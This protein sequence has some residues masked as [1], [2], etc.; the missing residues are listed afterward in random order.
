MTRFD[1][2]ELNVRR[3]V[4]S[5]FDPE[6]TRIL[7]YF[8]E[9]SFRKGRTAA[10][11]RT[12]RDLGEASGTAS[13]AHEA[14]KRLVSK[15]VLVR[16]PLA[17]LPIAVQAFHWYGFNLNFL[18]WPPEWKRPASF[19]EE[20]ELPFEPGFEELLRQS[21]IN[22]S[23]AG[24]PSAVSEPT[25][26][27]DAGPAA[28]HDADKDAPGCDASERSTSAGET[29]AQNTGCEVQNG[30]TAE[31]A[32]GAPDWAGFKQALAEGRAEEWTK[33]NCTP[34]KRAVPPQGTKTCTP[35]LYP[36]APCT[37]T[38]YS[39]KANE[40]AGKGVPQASPEA[41]PSRARAIASLACTNKA[42]LATGSARGR[43]PAV[44]PEGSS[45]EKSGEAIAWLQSVDP[46]PF[47]NKKFLEQW[48]ET[49]ERYPRYVLSK[50]RGVWEDNVRRLKAGEPVERIENPL[51][52]LA[53]VAR[54]EGRMRR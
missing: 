40:C 34:A 38:G 9:R 37:S 13:H 16:L 51:A 10:Y 49:C 29:T 6:E 46:R 33:E 24:A 44:P 50:L 54:Q 23:V 42:S 19:W 45:I 18:D 32:L 41:Y 48:L 11:F 28:V 52:Y 4:M 1:L 35:A 5:C 22:F 26:I 3:R 20:D 25:G 47:R 12:Y 8:V 7:E 21:T 27:R 14:L 15:K 30:K 2:I 36:A 43:G 53:G 31:Q 17:G 39:S